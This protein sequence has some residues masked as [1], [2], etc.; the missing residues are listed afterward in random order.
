MARD[1]LRQL[2]VAPITCGAPSGRT[3]PA[4]LPD[5]AARAPTA[6]EVVWLAQHTWARTVD[7]VLARRSRLLFL[8]IRQ[9]IAAAPAVAQALAGATGR[10]PELESFLLKARAWLARASG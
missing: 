6:E 5:C 8:D 3:L 1:A 4:D 7:D 2:P 10:D 9:A